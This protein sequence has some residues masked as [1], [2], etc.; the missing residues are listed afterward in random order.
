MNDKKTAIVKITISRTHI[1]KKNTF[2]KQFAKFV[3]D[4]LI[5]CYRFN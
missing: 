2:L 4:I 5:I 1:D 3:L